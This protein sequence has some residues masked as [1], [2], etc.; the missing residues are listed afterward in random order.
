MLLTHFLVLPLAYLAVAARI[1]IPLEQS[2]LSAPPVCCPGDEKWSV[3]P[4]HL[5]EGKCCAKDTT[6]TFDPMTAEGGCC[7]TGES[8]VG[9]TCQASNPISP[10]TCLNTPSTPKC[11]CPGS[12]TNHCPP[13]GTLGIQYGRCYTMSNLQGAPATRAINDSREWYY[14]GNYLGYRD[15]IFRVCKDETTDKSCDAFQG[16]YVPEGGSWHLIDQTGFFDQQ[17]PEYVGVLDVT[18]GLLKTKALGLTTSKSGPPQNVRS[19]TAQIK[20]LFGK[21][22]PCVR[23]EPKAGISDTN[24]GLYPMRGEAN[25]AFGDVLITSNLKGICAPI[26]FQETSCKSQV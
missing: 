5:E 13:K 17:T 20:C 25:P 19:F 15:L 10:P 2:P 21:C 3:D 12:N 24:L 9:R 16:Q 18:I 1:E 22:V 7:P 6:F 26:V 8:F 4:T 11:S 23:V 14:F